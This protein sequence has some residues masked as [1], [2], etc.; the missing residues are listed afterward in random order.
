MENSDYQ[1]L[2]ELFKIFSDETRLRILSFLKAGE[3]TVGEISDALKTSSSAVSHQLN[4]LRR[5]KLVKPR[6]DGR[7]IYY[8]L[9]DEHIGAILSCGIEHLEES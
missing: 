1:A 2:S 8:S 7:Q 3:K 4:L 6:R 5:S 9:D